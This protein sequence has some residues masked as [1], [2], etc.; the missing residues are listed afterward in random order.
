MYLL[1]YKCRHKM[2]GCCG[3]FLTLIFRLHVEKWGGDSLIVATLF[4]F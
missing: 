4:I 1:V 3:S 2:Q